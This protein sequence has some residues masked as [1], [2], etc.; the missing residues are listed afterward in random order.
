MAA[1]AQMAIVSVFLLLK[2]KELNKK[3][4]MSIITLLVVYTFLLMSLSG[5]LFFLLL[6][7]TYIL[8][9][10]A[11]R[12]S[13]RFVVSMVIVLLAF[14]SGL[15]LFTPFLKKDIYEAEQNIQLFFSS[16][17]EFVHHFPETPSSSQVRLVL[18]LASI[19]EIQEHPL[20]V[21]TGNVDY[22]LGGNL[23]EKGLNE[24]ATHNY[25]PHNQF[26]HTWLEIG[27]AGFFILISILVA[28]IRWGIKKKNIMA[29][30]LLANL[31]FNCLFESMLQQ[32]SGIIFY[33]LLLMIIHI[34]VESEK[35]ST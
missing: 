35:K 23:K 26:L 8:F 28:G 10:I 24:L 19:E 13:R 12:K 1:G 34:Y 33:P 30:I 17:E 3:M 7:A 4:A 2:K 27:V 31:T 9:K 5:V 14:F 21:G 32:Q 15:F 11:Q 18:W 20:G 6:S 25:N 22:Y 16:Q 29:V